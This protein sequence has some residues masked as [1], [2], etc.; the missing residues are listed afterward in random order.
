M[1]ARLILCTGVQYEAHVSVVDEAATAH[2]YRIFSVLRKRDSEA[3]GN[4]VMQNIFEPGFWSG[5]RCGEAAALAMALG[6]IR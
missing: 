2:S 5:R 6:N 1:R 3:A 4:L